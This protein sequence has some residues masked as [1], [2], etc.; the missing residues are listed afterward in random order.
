MDQD[1]PVSEGHQRDSSELNSVGSP[2][3]SIIS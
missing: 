1:S 2:K 3:I